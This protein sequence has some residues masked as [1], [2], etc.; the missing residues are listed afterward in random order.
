MAF[1]K[2]HDFLYFDNLRRTQKAETVMCLIH[3]SYQA[4]IHGGNKS[5]IAR[6]LKNAYELFRFDAG[7]YHGDESQFE[8]QYTIGHE[9][10][11]W[12]NSK[13]ELCDLATKV[14]K[15]EITIKEYFDIV[16][17]NYIQPID[18]KIVHPLAEVLHFVCENGLNEINKEQLKIIFSWISKQEKNN[19]NGLFNMLIG[20]SY[21]DKEDDNTL[22]I[23]YN[24]K[25]ILECCN[26]K[27]IESN[28][29]AVNNEFSDLHN[30]VEYLTTDHRSLQLIKDKYYSENSNNGRIEKKKN[31][32][33]GFNK[34]YYGIPGCGKSYKVDKYLKD[35]DIS[36]NNI[37]RT[38]FYLDYSNSDF[39]GQILPNVEDEKVTYEYIPGPFTK[40]LC[41]ALSTDEMVYLVIEEINRGNAPAIFGDIFQ[42]LDRKKITDQYGLKGESEYPIT[43]E[44][45]ESYLEKSVKGY[46]RSPIIIPS[47]LTIFA[48]MNTSDQNIFPLDTAFKRRWKLERVEGNIEECSF[49]DS[50]IPYTSITWRLFREQVNKK[51]SESALNGTITE[52]KK[53]GPWFATE[54]MFVT[55]K[56]IEELPLSIQTDRLLL[57]LYTVMDY[58][59]NDVCKFDKD[60]WFDDNK[61]FDDI[62][63]DIESYKNDNGFEK[64]ASRYLDLLFLKNE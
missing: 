13:L 7:S 24:P 49:K 15:N 27:Y 64:R 50:Y 42:L 39:I 62:C 8:S 63:K 18:N 46:T 14:A 34:I 56:E 22:R 10:G 59:Y 51:I 33:V 38:T 35:N 57:F 6:M 9:L 41:R 43:N 21:F 29:N 16:L 44:F 60:D 53:L 31:Q 61:S 58:L 23:N 1:C 2:N 19:I 48:T 25:D 26:R 52:D 17:L 3:A 45:I 37:F 20:T 32:N 11:I 12:K 40:A 5:D 28:L 36:Y 55:E 47:N 4:Q 54:D 30:Y